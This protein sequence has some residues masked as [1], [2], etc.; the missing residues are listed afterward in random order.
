[1]PE[2]LSKKK[3][4][5]KKK[6]SPGDRLREKCQ[7]FPLPEIPWEDLTEQNKKEQDSGR[8]QPPRE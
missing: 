6:H 2:H 8:E 4:F 1:M 5:Q 3:K 7:N